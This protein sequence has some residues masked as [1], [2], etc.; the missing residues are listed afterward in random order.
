MTILIIVVFYLILLGFCIH[1]YE[2]KL[3]SMKEAHTRTIAHNINL[4]DSNQKILFDNSILTNM[5]QDH[6]TEEEIQKMFKEKRN[7]KLK[8]M[9]E[10][11]YDG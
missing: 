6:F 1:K 3:D 8:K 10:E 7:E 11:R 2:G 9:E 5:L 4:I